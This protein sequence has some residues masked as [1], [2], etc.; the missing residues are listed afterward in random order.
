MLIAIVT[1]TALLLPTPPTSTDPV[2]TTVHTINAL[3]AMHGAPPLSLDSE[4][5][6]TA[7]E[8]ADHLQSTNRFEH[9]PHNPYGENL[10]ETGHNRSIDSAAADALEDWYRESRRYDYSEEM[11]QSNL[12]LSLLHFTAMVWK[13]SDRVGVGLAQGR[14]GTYVVVNFAARGNTLNRFRANVHPPTEG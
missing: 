2:A 7:Q 14:N 11:T 9:R 1:A 3:R 4:V 5:S 10:Y 12:D 13:S 6:R 8:W